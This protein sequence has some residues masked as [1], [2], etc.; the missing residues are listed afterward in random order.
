MVLVIRHEFC[1]ILLVTKG[2]NFWAAA[3]VKKAVF[4]PK[5]TRRSASWGNFNSILL[6]SDHFQFHL[7][8]QFFTIASGIFS[9][10]FIQLLPTYIYLDA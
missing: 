10:S 2:G 8:L 9:S 4:Y 5:F 7:L 1:Q 6:L 3:T